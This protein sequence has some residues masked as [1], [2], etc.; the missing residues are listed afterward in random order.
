MIDP[1][2]IDICNLPY[3]DLASR[4]DLPSQSAIY[5]AIDGQENI[6][7]IG[8]S[9]NL[10]QRWKSHHKIGVLKLVGKIRIAYLLLDTDLLASVETALIDYFNPPLNGNQLGSLRNV[11]IT[12]SLS[13]DDKASLEALAAKHGCMWGK[14]PNISRLIQQIAIGQLKIVAESDKVLEAQTLLK[15]ATVKR[16]Y[17]LLEEQFKED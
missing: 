9:A 17:E 15:S 3:V 16:L 12:L 6:Q 4:F 11:S 5:F 14:T 13:A 8:R 2:T 1:R 7:Y 10:N